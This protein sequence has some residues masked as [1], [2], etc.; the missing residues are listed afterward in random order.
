[1]HGA[2][3]NGYGS[4]RF[5]EEIFRRYQKA[6]MRSPPKPMLHLIH[7]KLPRKIEAFRNNSEILR[8]TIPGGEMM[9]VGHRAAMQTTA[10]TWIFFNI[11]DLQHDEKKV[12]TVLTMEHTD[13]R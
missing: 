1:M 2:D 11:V 8:V 6:G 4:Y 7:L 10:H 13:E 12:E 3:S 9:K 5:E